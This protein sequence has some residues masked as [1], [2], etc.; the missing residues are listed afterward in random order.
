[1]PLFRR[2]A[3]LA[4]VAAGFAV[5]SSPASAAFS[6]DGSLPFTLDSRNFTVHYQS[7]F[8]SSWAITQTQAGDIG[9]LADRALAAEM[10]DGYPR[11]LSDVA[12]DGNDKIDIYVED[13]SS[14]PGVL[15][16]AYWDF[17][18]PQTSGFIELAGNMQEA[19]FNQHVIAHELFHLIQFSIWLPTALATGSNLSD[20]WLLEGSAEW[21]GFRVDGYPD[22][23]GLGPPD[24][25]L[26]CRD[27][28]G[29]N[30]CDLTDDYLNDGYSR[31]PFFEFLSE[32]YGPAFV[33][34][35]FADGAS[36]GFAT[37]LSALSAALAAK[38]T[39]LDATYNAWALAELTSNYSIAALKAQRPQP[40]NFSP[41][42]TGVATTTD[43]KP[44]LSGKVAVNH[45]STRFIEFARG[46][47][48]GGS[49]SAPCWQ[50]TLKLTVTFPAS[51]LS[52]PVF[53]WDGPGAVAT[54]LSVN[55]GTATASIPWDTCTWSYGEG[56]LSL[57]NA[58][59]S[60][61][62]GVD[63]ADFNVT[64]NLVLSSPLVQVTS[65]VPATPP[66]GVVVTTPVIQVSTLDIAPTISV[67]GPELLK[68]SAGDSQI[69]LIVSSSGQGKVSA[70]LGSHVLG[71]MNLRAGSNDLRFA[72]P[73]GTL[74]SVRT[75]SV[76][77]NV[78]TLTPTSANGASTGAVVKRTIS[79]APEAKKPAAKKAAAKKPAAKKKLSTTK[80]GK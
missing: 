24:M 21:M 23:S 74:A 28:Y 67:F 54:P 44:V 22:P 29:T 80:H 48:A 47:A 15:A 62:T 61:S 73:K 66:P 26:D 53:Y 56:F 31:W 58:S 70:S 16:G 59:S 27:K 10:A 34:D 35:I 45:L 19:A 17:N 6:R 68:L 33:K 5:L 79:V 57:P 41:V 42:F 75:S 40:Y 32:K 11:P 20:A 12:V 3:L 38:G 13:Y 64:A 71:T 1:M 63:A 14:S 37:S 25:A 4:V 77:S 50:A 69:R 49:T 65:I 18:T 30:Q 7:V 78:L 52:Q 55:G 9:A 8:G 2:I 43:A 46:P 76:A 39:T 72:I 51:A 36:A 60:S